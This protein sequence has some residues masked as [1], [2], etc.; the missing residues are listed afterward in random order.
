MTT[1]EY[2]ERK[3]GLIILGV[4]FD[5][6]TNKIIECGRYYTTTQA[7]E[8]FRLYDADEVTVGMWHKPEKLVTDALTKIRQVIRTDHDHTRA[9][10]SLEEWGRS[11][12][13]NQAKWIP[14]PE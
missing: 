10:S 12:N 13:T 2:L 5:H 1:A 8:R 14:L 9:W 11:E 7:V 6:E 3:S 4:V